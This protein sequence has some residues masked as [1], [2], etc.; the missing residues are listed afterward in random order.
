[1]ASRL[2]RFPPKPAGESLPPTA[3]LVFSPN[4][5]SIRRAGGWEFLMMKR[6]EFISLLGG[7]T[8]MWPL[9]ARAQQSDRMRRI[10]VL[11]G[12]AENDE[13]WQV[14]LATFRQ[15]LQ[16]FG[17]TEGRNLRIDY[18]FAGE[19]NQRIHAAAQELAAGAP[20][21]IF[22]STNPVVSAVMQA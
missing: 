10:G 21:V 6:R 1:M 3:M 14:Y 17:W 15:R 8:A 2:S 9:A 12:F 19:N 4:E 16:D 22:V 11:M 13:V 20:D 18:R 7:A 5:L